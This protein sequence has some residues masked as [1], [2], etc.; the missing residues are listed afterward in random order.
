MVAI[1]TVA[2][3]IINPN[4]MAGYTSLMAVILVL[5]GVL[6]FVLG[7][8]GEYIGQTYLALNNTPQFVVKDM[9]NFDE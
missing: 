7:I 9:V 4:V 3:K 2:R 1:V 5:F 6:F 8:F